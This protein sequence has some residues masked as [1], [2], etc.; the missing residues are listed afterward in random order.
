MALSSVRRKSLTGE[1]PDK[2]DREVSALLHAPRPNAA[3]V[4]DLWQLLANGKE[5]LP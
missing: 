1:M 5:P 2:E 4:W 3:S